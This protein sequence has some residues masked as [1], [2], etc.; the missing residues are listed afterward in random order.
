MVQDLEHQVQIANVLEQR[1]TM[2]EQQVR[3]LQSQNQGLR[4]AMRREQEEVVP[5]EPQVLPNTPPKVQEEST[6][7]KCCTCLEALVGF[8]IFL[9]SRTKYNLTT[10]VDDRPDALSPHGPLR[11]LHQP[12]RFHHLPNVQAR[13]SRQNQGLLLE[14]PRN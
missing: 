12:L 10:L 1:S 8:L 7:G 4:E 13:R 14:R 6:A 3:N 11:N 9:D 5:D 2:L